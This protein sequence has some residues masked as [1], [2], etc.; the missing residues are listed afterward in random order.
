MAT[1]VYEPQNLKEEATKNMMILDTAVEIQAVVQL[2]VSKG[3]I[4]NVE[5]DYMRNQTKDSPKYKAVYEMAQKAISAA[6]L[7]EKNPQAYL[8]ELFKAKLNGNL[9]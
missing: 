9:R 7:Y 2:L 6:E 1:S 3:I 5:M 8:Q 4:A